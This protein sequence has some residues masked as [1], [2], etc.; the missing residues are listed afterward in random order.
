MFWN[1]NTLGAASTAVNSS[2][3]EAGWAL[4]SQELHFEPSHEDYEER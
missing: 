3:L 4:A 2:D 1:S